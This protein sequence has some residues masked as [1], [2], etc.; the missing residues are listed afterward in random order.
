MNKANRNKLNFAGVNEIFYEKE[1][2]GMIAKE[3]AG[4]YVAFEAIHALRTSY[5]GIEI[6]EVLI[7]E[8][9]LESVASVGELA[10]KKYRIVLLGIHKKNKNHFFFNPIDSTLLEA[11]DHLLVIGNGVFLK[12]FNIHLHQKVSKW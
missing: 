12:E 9:I 10:N 11:G 6:Q 1:L 8:R 7:T 3:F 5:K 2:V 4:K